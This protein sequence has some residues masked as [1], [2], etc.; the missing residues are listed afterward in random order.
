MNGHDS[1]DDKTTKFIDLSEIK[2]H[3][4]NVQESLAP[5]ELEFQHIHTA[6]S[7]EEDLPK[8]EKTSSDQEKAKERG[9]VEGKRKIVFF[10]HFSP[11]FE[12][13]NIQLP[14]ESFE[15]MYAKDV[16]EVNEVIKEKNPFILVLNFDSAPKEVNKICLQVNKKFPQIKTIIVSKKISSQK[17]DVHSQSPAR[18]HGYLG[19]PLTADRLLEVLDDIEEK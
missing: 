17:K 7:D 11:F 14:Q 16:S 4:S 13:Q 1:E 12:D 6:T 18:A 5:N 2:K 10:D 8:N 9:E 19:H 3:N 15:M